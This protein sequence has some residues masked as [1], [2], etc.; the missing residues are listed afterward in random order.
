MVAQIILFPYI[1]LLNPIQKH[2]RENKGFDSTVVVA[3][4]LE[5][6]RQRPFNIIQVEEKSIQGILDT[7]ADKSCMAGKDWPGT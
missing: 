6:T 2:I 3:W 5:I 4:T 7:G 1:E